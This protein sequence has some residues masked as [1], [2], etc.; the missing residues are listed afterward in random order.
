MSIGVFYFKS[1][2]SK[3][4]HLRIGN[5]HQLTAKEANS[6]RNEVMEFANTTFKKIYIDAKD[7]KEAD[8]SG[9]NEIIHTHY[10]LA[11]HNIKM[12]LIYRKESAVEKWVHTTGLDRF[13]E[14]AL[15]PV[16]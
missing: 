10:Q 13:I 5:L 1:T 7:V 15:L 6:I 11:A 12:V 8:L 4:G 14:T 2:D 3:N 9:I 16:Q